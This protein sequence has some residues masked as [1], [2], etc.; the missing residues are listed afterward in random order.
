MKV[1][2]EDIGFNPRTFKLIQIIKKHSLRL[3]GIKQPS[4]FK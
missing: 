1:S 3:T 2:Q 4:G